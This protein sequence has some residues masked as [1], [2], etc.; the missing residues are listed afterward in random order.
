M[1][2]IKEISSS[3]LQSNGKDTI[4]VRKNYFA[5]YSAGG[6]NSGFSGTFW[7]GKKMENVINKIFHRLTSSLYL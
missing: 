5:T 6:Y 4:K 2:S 1:S 7:K 3:I